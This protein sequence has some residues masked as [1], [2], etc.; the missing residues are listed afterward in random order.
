MARADRPT[1]PWQVDFS[2][3]LF[4]RS[5][6]YQIGREIIA[7][8]AELIAQIWY[9]RVTAPHPPEGLSAR[10]IGKAEHIEHG[11]RRGRGRSREAR[12]ADGH[13]WLHLDP[14]SLIHRPPREG[15]LVVVHDLGPLTHPHLFSSATIAAYP[16]AYQTLRESG[17]TAVFVSRDSQRQF[18][19]L[20]GDGQ[21][22]QVIYPP[23]A[24]RLHE[25]EVVRPKGAGDKFLL[26]VGAVGE[27]KNQL[28]SIEAFAQSGLA[29]QGYQYLLCGGRE[30]GFAKV[31]E[32][33]C[34]VEGVKVLPFV[35]NAELRWLYQNASGFV[36]ASQL[37][38]FGMPVA[39][40]MA[41]GLVPVISRGT[42]MEEVAGEAAICVDP[43]D[44]GEIAAAMRAAA[45]MSPASLAARQ[46][47]MAKQIGRFSAAAFQSSWRALLTANH[48]S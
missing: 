42:V 46:S 11:W 44:T 26:T 7:H 2:L 5:G 34:E 22:G 1:A 25:G 32:R 48:A 4:N 12:P 24:P 3:A 43:K 23:V 35:S 40:A 21:K 47:A 33:A 6:K 13:R 19:R 16:F 28:R 10:I 14:L 9:W 39:E 37:E 36:L 31:V 15:D 45:H 41:F 18:A 8:N 17:A 38:G 20:Y 29:E 27:R 30:P